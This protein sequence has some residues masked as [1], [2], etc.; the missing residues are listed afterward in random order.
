MYCI[1]LVERRENALQM[2]KCFVHFSNLHLVRYYKA[3]KFICMVGR[4]NLR[5]YRFELENYFCVE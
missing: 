5:N 3:E 1:K 2:I 4:T